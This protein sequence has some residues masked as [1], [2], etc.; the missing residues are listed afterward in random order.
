MQVPIIAESVADDH[1]EIVC[2]FFTK[3]A[4]ARALS[5]PPHDRKKGFVSQRQYTKRE[6][7]PAFQA[8]NAR[9]TAP[10]GEFA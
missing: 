9:S 10:M 4:S 3:L 2:R 5:A 6:Y 1:H 8:E 7:L